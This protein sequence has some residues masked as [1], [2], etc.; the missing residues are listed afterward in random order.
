MDMNSVYVLLAS[1]LIAEAAAALF[2]G[3]PSRSLGFYLISQQALP[4]PGLII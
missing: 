1:R 3:D 4:T 2:C